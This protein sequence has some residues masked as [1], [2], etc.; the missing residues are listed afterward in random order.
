MCTAAACVICFETSP[1]PTQSGC[2]GSVA[3]CAREQAARGRGEEHARLER[4]RRSGYMR[5]KTAPPFFFGKFRLFTFFFAFISFFRGFGG[6][7][8]SNGKEEVVAPD[9]L[10]GRVP[11]A[12]D[13]V[14]HIPLRAA[15]ILLCPLRVVPY[16]DE[17]ERKVAL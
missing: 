10:D 6:F 13:R 7:G 16:L 4:R 12:H 3:R 5:R 11:E 17:Q 2:G 8:L 9:G 14:D 1:A 15:H